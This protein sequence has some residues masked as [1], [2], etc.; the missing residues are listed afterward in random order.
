MSAPSNAPIPPENSTAVRANRWALS[1]SR[2][3][4]RWVLL[5]IGLYVALP[6]VAPTLMH[7]GLTG[8]ANAIYTA[9]SPLCHQFAFRSWF[10]FGEQAAYPR[11][12]A[13]VDGLQP[14]DAFTPD[15]QQATGSK[16]DL[17]QWTEDLI[18]SARAFIGDPKMGYKVALCE[19]DIA[20][21]LTLFIGGLIFSI[22]YV[23]QHLRPIPLWLYVVLGIMPIAID[24]FSQLL[25]YP[26]FNFWPIRETTPFFRTLTGALFGFVNA[27]L[28]FPHLEDTAHQAVVEFERK[29]A[30]RRQRQIQQDNN[31]S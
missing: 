30:I 16:V 1:L 29:F 11:A 22:P 6:F 31:G 19:R 14:F 26:P 9:Y 13:H 24:G 2:H 12:V 23:R 3:W 8:P 5:V 21:Y 7:F 27:W 28:A 10:L 18:Y 20:I 17:S 25:G 4:L 15:V